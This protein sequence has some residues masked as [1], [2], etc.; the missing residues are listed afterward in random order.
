MAFSMDLRQS[1][2]GAWQEGENTQAELAQLFGVSSSW[3]AKLLARWR[4]TGS[5]APLAHG[6]GREPALDATDEDWVEQW[7]IR[8]PDLT[9]EELQTRLADRTGTCA[10]HATLCRVCQRLR[11]PRKKSRC[12]PPSGTVPTY[13]INGRIGVSVSRP[14]I[15]NIRSLWMKQGLHGR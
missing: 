7:L 12:T 15:Q 8:Q 10:S 1:I 13:V 2:V 6:G 14:S 4:N 11:L 5:L 3:L 9:L